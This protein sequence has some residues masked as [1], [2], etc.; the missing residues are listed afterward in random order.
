MES[1]FMSKPLRD[2]AHGSFGGLMAVKDG[3][4]AAMC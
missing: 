1:F 4:G 3:N 2:C